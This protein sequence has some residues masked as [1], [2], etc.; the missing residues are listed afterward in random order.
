MQQFFYIRTDNK[1]VQIKF[2]D[3]LYGEAKGNF[4][5]LYC[6]KKNYMVSGLLT[7]VSKALPSSSFYRIHRSYIVLIE[8]VKEFDKERVL[9][10]TGQM[11]PI[12]R[13]YVNEFKKR[14]NIVGRGYVHHRWK[15]ENA[16]IQK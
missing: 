6:S 2:T 16:L 4:V 15:A 12:G 13:I 7:E 3:V 10:D 1:Y 14:I 11:L 9:L 5:K 8:R